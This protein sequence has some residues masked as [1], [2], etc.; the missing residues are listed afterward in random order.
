MLLGLGLIAPLCWWTLRTEI[1]AGGT[2]LVEASLL[3]IVVFVLF[4]LVL[5]NE[6]VRRHH[7][8]QALTPPELITVYILLTSSVGLSGLGE[9]QFLN[10]A[11]AGA[12]SP[13]QDWKAFYPYIPSWWV[14]DPAVLPAYFKGGSTFFTPEH[15]RGWA[16]PIAAWTLFTLLKVTCFLCLNTL[17]RRHWVEHERLTFPLVAVP[18]EMTRAGAAGSLVTRREFWLAF[19][20]A[21]LFRSLT[22]IHRLNPSFPDPAAFGPK[23]QL[24]DLQ[25]YF[26]EH[27]WSGIGY[28]RISF[29]PVILGITYFLPLD[30]SFSAWFFY[31]LV[32]AE[33]VLA[34]ALGVRDPGA[35]PAADQPPYTGEQGA[36]AFLA[37]AFFALWGARRHLRDVFGKA[38]GARR[39]V[40]DDDEPL[41]YRAAVFGFVGSL[42]GLVL[43]VAL[44]GLPWHLAALFF[45]LYLLMILACTRLRAEAGPM[46]G[47]GPSFNPHQMMVTLP[48]SQA[49]DLRTLTPFSYLLW[50]DTGYRAVAMPQQMETL[51]MTSVVGGPY[52]QERPGALRL[53]AGLMLFG[54]L[55]AAVSSFISVLAIYY[56][57]GALFPGGD[58]PWRITN[59]RLP[60]VTIKRWLDNPT[61]PDYARMGWMTLG[62]VTT[63]ALVKARSLF[64]WWPFH[65]SGFALAHAQ[66]AMQW[67]WFPV[68][69][70]WAVKA[71]IL[72]WG[73]MTMFRRGIPFFTGL[74]LGDIVIG[75]VW[76]IIGVAL[77]TQVYMFFPG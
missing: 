6:W 23:G 66:Q 70:T 56:H 44:G 75:M 33:Y 53:L 13:A 24:I 50:F 21:C 41:S 49:W 74:I 51:K 62:F 26:T 5:L 36:G 12:W 14:P 4:L 73:G 54:A 30:V 31:L 64:F 46:L 32:K 7:P 69:I 22:G 37:L 2:E 38:F 47:Y 55:I 40:R 27:P 61:F 60:F 67:V 45:G 63:A 25:P 9:M 17:L 77:E 68:L 72:R 16:A 71:M 76:S 1:I 10:Q 15:L 39:S 34:V 43:F 65:P 42:A 11:L 20:L 35:S 29:H 52:R 57:Y 8:R 18:L 19:G 3:M 58:N 48:G 59:G 28:F